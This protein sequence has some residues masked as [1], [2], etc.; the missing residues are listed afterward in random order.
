MSVKIVQEYLASPNV[1]KAAKVKVAKDFALK[2]MPTKVED[3]TAEHY[4]QHFKG[5]DR[6]TLERFADMCAEGIDAPRPVST[7][8]TR[9]IVH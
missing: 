6:A 3:V 8:R 2:K 4:M 9:A 1:K 5:L 7:N